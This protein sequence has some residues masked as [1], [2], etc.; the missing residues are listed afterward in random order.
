MTR[1]TST[2][3]SGEAR[4]ARPSGAQ[5]DPAG[6]PASG[7]GRT[8]TGWSLPEV[9]DFLAAY[10]RTPS[11]L[12]AAPLPGGWENLNLSVDADAEQFVLR[13]YDVT[14]PAEVQWEIELIGYLTERAFPTPALI[15]RLD[16]GKLGIFGGRPAALFAFVAGHHP[17]TDTPGAAAA[18]AAIVA[19]LHLVT[20]GLALPYPRTRLDNRRRL[21]R[22][23]EWFQARAAAP[24]EPALRR[25]LDQ[26]TQYSAE[27]AARLEAVTVAHGALPRGVVHHDAHGNNLLFDDAGRLVALLDFDDAHETFLLADVA[28][29]L[30][31]WGVERTQ[32]RFEP[33]RARRVLD[34]YVRRRPLTPAERDL[35]PDVMALYNLADATS[36]VMGRIEE[37]RPAERAVADCNQYARFC[38]RTA[39]QDWRDRL[40]DQLA[41][42]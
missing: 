37:G 3:L 25:L 29:L 38:E 41:L 40:R 19:E 14:D 21:R 32:Y 9:R 15:P 24:D 18:A 28:V 6:G 10:G 42:R 31:S 27:L 1:T 26:T 23:Q 16:G 17:R 39:A 35:L 7:W 30:D 13:R 5:P 22:F 20:A 8:A 2:Q 36:Y 4:L 12:E 33:D 34:A 11:R